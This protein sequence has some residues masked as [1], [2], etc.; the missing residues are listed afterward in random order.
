MCPVNASGVRFRLRRGTT[1]FKIVQTLS[2][3]EPRRDMHRSAARMKRIPSRRECEEELLR[4]YNTALFAWKHCSAEE[5]PRFQREFLEA[6]QRFS[7]CVLR[8]RPPDGS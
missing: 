8:G 5:E 3:K 7:D 4:Q 6:L 1:W 2:P